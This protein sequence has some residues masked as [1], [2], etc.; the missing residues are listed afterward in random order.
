MFDKITVEAVVAVSAAGLQDHTDFVFLWILLH[1]AICHSVGT[2]IQCAEDDHFLT[3]SARW[4]MVVVM[5]NASPLTTM[6]QSSTGDNGVFIGTV[7]PLKE[8]YDIWIHKIITTIIKQTQEMAFVSVVLAQARPN[9]IFVQI[10]SLPYSGKFS[11]VQ[12]FVFHALE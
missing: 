9:K 2:F 8:T 3:W 12:I 1:V 5:V 6:L 7:S 4:L 11:L 10:L